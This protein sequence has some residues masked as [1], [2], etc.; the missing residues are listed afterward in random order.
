MSQEP[1]ADDQTENEKNADGEQKDPCERIF[2]NMRDAF[3]SG[4]EEAKQK[5]QEGAPDIDSA[6]GKAAYAISYGAAFSS[7]FG[8]TMA[9]ELVT[10]VMKDGGTEGFK[11]GKAA[12]ERAVKPKSTEDGA[13]VVVDAEYTVR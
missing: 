8:L 13:E 12:A 2:K 7:S 4:T 1:F 10:G 5:A 6:F 9:K 11:D 3:K